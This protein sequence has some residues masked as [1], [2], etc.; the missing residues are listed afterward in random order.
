MSLAVPSRSS[1]PRLSRQEKRPMWGGLLSIDQAGLATRDHP[2]ADGLWLNVPLRASPKVGDPPSARPA[3]KHSEAVVQ[4][5]GPRGAWAPD[6][7]PN[8]LTQ[9][10][11]RASAIPS[12]GWLRPFDMETQRQTGQ[13]LLRGIRPVLAGACALRG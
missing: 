3:R 12:I 10:V 5:E 4:D 2:L 1:C 7:G 9:T 11:N 13:P 6:S 8:P